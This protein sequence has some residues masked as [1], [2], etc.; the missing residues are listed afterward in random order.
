L[1]D[2][3]SQVFGRQGGTEALLDPTAVLV[4]HQL[5]DLSP[6]LL[7]LGVIAAPARSPVL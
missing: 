4:P 1:S 7:F 5:Q 3:S 2:L 6:E